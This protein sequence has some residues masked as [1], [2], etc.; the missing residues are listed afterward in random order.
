MY[1]GHIVRLAFVKLFN[2]L[3]QKKEK[4]F[5]L[6]AVT[7]FK[8]WNAAVKFF[9][10]SIRHVHMSWHLIYTKKYIHQ[11]IC[12]VNNPRIIWRTKGLSIPRSIKYS[13][14]FY[15]TTLIWVV[16]KCNYILIQHNMLIPKMWKKIKNSLTT[17]NLLSKTNK[18]STVF[19]KTKMFY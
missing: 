9:P 16:I 13:F 4:L 8:H 12:C 2:V 6:Q 17:K 5:L 3:E 15:R 18:N 11:N 19:Q 1:V 7:S 14:L 10:T